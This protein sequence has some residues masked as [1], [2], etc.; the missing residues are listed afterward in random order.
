MNWHRQRTSAVWFCCL[1]CL[2]LGTSHAAPPHYEP[3]KWNLS[4][5]YTVTDVPAA[6]FFNRS[7]DPADVLFPISPGYRIVP[8]GDRD[9]LSTVQL[10]C[11]G[12]GQR[13]NQTLVA[14]G[15]FLPGCTQLAEFPTYMCWQ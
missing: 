14:A 9:Y 8:D 3:T 1:C 13:V 7:V 6:A 4:C 2:H 15:A 10:S 11:F 5:N 12:P